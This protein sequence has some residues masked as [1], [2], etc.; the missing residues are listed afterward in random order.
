[1]IARFIHKSDWFPALSADDDAITPDSLFEGLMIQQSVLKQ[2]QQ[3]A[4]WTPA[5]AK[6]AE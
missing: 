6:L 3:L 4:E 1:M 2:D 5:P